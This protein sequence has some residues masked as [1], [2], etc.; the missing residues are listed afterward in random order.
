M[1]TRVINV[2]LSMFLVSLS[3][4]CFPGRFSN[5]E[6]NCLHFELFTLEIDE[7]QKWWI[8]V[9][10]VPLMFRLHFDPSHHQYIAPPWMT[11]CSFEAPSSSLI[12]FI[13]F[14]DDCMYINLPSN[15][16]LKP[17]SAQHK[18]KCHGGEGYAFYQ[19][20]INEIWRRG[21]QW[22]KYCGM[23]WRRKA[24]GFMSN[25]RKLKAPQVLSSAADFPATNYV[26][27]VFI[28]RRK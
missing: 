22:R 26:I 6:K 15:T 9:L 18:S 4:D 16:P 28:S 21:N 3:F 1:C 24:K 2:Y 5:T 19:R 7:L 25:N 17:L 10:G 20:L 27:L 8:L 23:T 12:K 11:Q 13:S 14:I